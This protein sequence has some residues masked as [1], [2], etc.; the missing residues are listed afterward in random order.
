MI[1]INN[2]VDEPRV[3]PMIEEDTIGAAV[4][5]RDVPLVA[6]P[7]CLSCSFPPLLPV[8][9]TIPPT[10]STGL[11]PAG[12]IPF[13]PANPRRSLV[14]RAGAVQPR[15]PPRVRERDGGSGAALRPGPGLGTRG[16]ELGTRSSR[17]PAAPKLARAPR[18]RRRVFRGK[19]LHRERP[20]PIR[21]CLRGNKRSTKY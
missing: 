16:S 7:S 3:R 20:G 4:T 6:I 11:R 19:W 18:E 10:S 2:G 5:E 21:W 12:P 13:S 14:T 17:Q 15:Q 1:S 9:A 8:G